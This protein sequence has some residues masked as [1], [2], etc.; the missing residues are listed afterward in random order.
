MTT[1][2]RGGF[3]AI[4]PIAENSWNQTNGVYGE[5]FA[6]M[7][8]TDRLTAFNEGLKQCETFLAKAPLNSIAAFNSETICRQ[9]DIP[10]QNRLAQC[11]FA[12]EVQ[13]NDAVGLAVADG[14]SVYCLATKRL[15]FSIWTEASAEYG[16]FNKD[17][18]W[19]SG[20]KVN[21]Q[22]CKDGSYRAT[23]QAGKVL[24][25]T[26]SSILSPDPNKSRNP[27]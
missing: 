12:M 14:K 26:V 9:S 18:K 13:N 3:L 15:F 25:L 21:L 27:Q 24:K 22:D 2:A 16:A 10:P 20:D 19:V 4:Y 17:G 6:K 5:N 8:W 23:Y 7:P 11:M 1:L